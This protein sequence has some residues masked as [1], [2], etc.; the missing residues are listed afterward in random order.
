M[1]LT[2][3]L[4]VGAVIVG[5]VAVMYALGMDISQL[6]VMV[7]GG[8]R[9]SRHFGLIGLVAIII[10]V[11]LASIFGMGGSVEPFTSTDASGNTTVSG[12]VDVSGSA[13]V[14]GEVGIGGATSVAGDIVHVGSGAFLSG[15]A[16]APGATYRA[17]IVSK[18]MAYSDGAKSA[19]NG[20]PA[21]TFIIA[22]PQLWKDG[23]TYKDN[24]FF[25]YWNGLDGNQYYS[26]IQGTAL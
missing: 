4:I 19:L 17:G 11:M 25:L 24:V 16:L 10:A 15:G 2:T 5:V 8:V 14:I 26:S 20:Q 7:G 3:W 23:S 6:G 9:K 21:G 1:N 22:G 18:G 13:N 12:N